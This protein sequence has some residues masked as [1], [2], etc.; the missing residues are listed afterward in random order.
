MIKIPNPIKEI[1]KVR[2]KLLKDKAEACQ[3]EIQQVLDK[4]NLEL[5]AIIQSSA[6]GIFPAHTLRPKAKK[7]ALKSQL[8]R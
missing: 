1:D 2:A 5:I 6:F 3:K 8:E 4:H 7:N